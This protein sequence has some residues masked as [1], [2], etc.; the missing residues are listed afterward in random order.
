M[1]VGDLRSLSGR[2]TGTR[3]VH[4]CGNGWG[5]CPRCLC[6]L[7]LTPTPVVATAIVP[8]SGGGHSGGSGNLGSGS[9]VPAQGLNLCPWGAAPRALPLLR[10]PE[11]RCPLAYPPGRCEQNAGVPSAASKYGMPSGSALQTAIRVLTT[12]PH[13]SLLP[14]GQP[15]SPL[16]WV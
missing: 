3:P 9:T 13:L 1:A 12:C 16:S 10:I 5:G 11:V 7:V 15:G 14:S 4:F 8:I 2:E 6:H